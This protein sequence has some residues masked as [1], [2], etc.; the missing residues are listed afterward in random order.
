MRMRTL[1]WR[2]IFERKSQLLTSFLAV[3]LGITVI[4]SIKN[5]TFYSEKAVAGEMDL[6]GANVMVLPK[7]ATL[8]DYYAA[9][10][11][12]ETIPEEYVTR[13]A[14]SDL[15]GLDNLSPKLSLPIEVK[16]E[17]YTLTG[18]LPKSEF[19]A[20]AAW[21]G[22]GIFARP[23]TGC[24][25][26]VRMPGAPQDE[27]KTLVRKR[28]IQD[29]KPDEI[30]VGAD[31]AASLKA[32]EGEMLDLLGKQF[33]VTAVLPQTGT[34]DDA[35]IFAHLHTVQELSGKGPVLSAIEVVGC[36]QEISKGLVQKINSLLPDAKVVTIT[37]IVDAQ[38]NMNA[39]MS[40]LSTIFLIIIVMVGGAG[41]ANYMYA[42]VFERRREIGTFMALGA[43]SFLVL[44][45]FLFKALLLGLAGG[46]GGY[47]LG[48]ALAMILG[49]KLAGVSVSPMPA[50]A[51]LALIISV[52][53]TIVASFFPARR[54]ARLD[55]CA[56]FQ[57]I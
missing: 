43:D 49:P 10:R 13:L 51:A 46:V 31:A 4:V 54:A 48:T 35:R 50:L 2:E 16:S 42:N 21:Q 22:A 32:K 39:L 11:Q 53:L 36:C 1:V 20:K 30:L 52:G 47:L 41:I 17:K 23:A 45:I 34:V 12:D 40:R 3:L 33:T 19:Q 7:S 5:I 8:Q 18:I 44:R 37:Q 14:M 28:V 6:L 24:G 9:D 38:R 27:K 26:A 56:T 15:Q 29:L 57:E 25:T 55:P